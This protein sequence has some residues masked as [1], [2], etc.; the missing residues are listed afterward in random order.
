MI[1]NSIKILSIDTSCDETAAAVTEDLKILSNVVWSQASLHAKWGGVMPSLAKREHEERIDWVVARAVQ[2]AKYKVQDLDAIAVT[3]GPGLA[4]ALEVGIK[5]AKELAK[6][7]NLPLVPVNHLEGHLLSCLAQPRSTKNLILKIKNCFPALGLVISGGNTQIILIK[8]IGKYEVL[9][10]TIDDALGESLDK[11]ARLLGLGYPG[12]AILEKLAEKG[13][14]K[15]YPLPLPFQGDRNNNKI[16]YSGLK[17][18][19][20]HLVAKIGRENLTK[21]Q[22]YDLAASYQS[23]AFEHLLRV[24]S[25]IIRNSQFTIHNVFVGG[26]V[27]ANNELRK[28]LRKLGKENNITVHFPYTKALCGDNA[29][30]IGVAAYFKFQRGEILKGEEIENLDREP[31]MEINKES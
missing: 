30:M 11:S 22:I 20:I 19:F 26:G 27:S 15:A 17:T 7:Y 23:T 5:K 12:G 25:C 21:Q 4:I 9:T 6:K 8:E 14:P 29:A 1:H 16:S 18:A 10:Q 28:R 24:L 3:R 2:R 13:D 31:R